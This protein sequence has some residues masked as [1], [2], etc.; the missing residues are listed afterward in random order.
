SEVADATEESAFS[1]VTWSLLHTPCLRVGFAPRPSP[2]VSF[3]A[4]WPDISSSSRSSR[5][6]RP[7][8]EESL[9]GIHLCLIHESSSLELS[10][11]S[12][13]SADIGN[14]VQPAKDGQVKKTS[15]ASI[16]LFNQDRIL[17]CSVPWG[18]RSVFVAPGFSVRC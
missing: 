16:A 11:Q 1:T 13:F 9:C 14:G 18:V 4:K 6:V 8:R 2:H 3:R 5:D 7:R 15:A 17:L 12:G 10:D